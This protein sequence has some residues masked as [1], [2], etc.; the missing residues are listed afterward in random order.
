LEPG[1]TD[2]PARD[3]RFDGPTGI[4][5]D[6][7]GNLYVADSRNNRIRVLSPDGKTST[8]A[9]GDA[10]FQDGDAKQ[11]RFNAPTGVAVAPDGTVYVADTLNHR[12]RAISKGM[13]STVSGGAAG[14]VDGAAANARFNL[15]SGLSI[16]APT[17]GH[18]SPLYVA[19]AGNR[20]I[21]AVDLG[22]S[23]VVRT[24][25]V[26]PGA[27]LSV[28]AITGAGPED[29]VATVPE[30]QTISTN[31]QTLK[32]IPIDAREQAGIVKPGTFELKNPVSLWPS[33]ANNKAWFALDSGHAVV[34]LIR[35]GKAEVI[36]GAAAPKA[37]M[38]GFRDNFGNRASFGLMGGIVGDGKG[39]LYISDTSNNAIRKI[40]LPKDL[41]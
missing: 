30:T 26:V 8:L 33:A 40:T 17:A 16:G 41:Y 18:G 20:S 6:A 37:N 23:P 31:T 11:A 32:A 14:K 13:V 35:N 9:G 4:A 7:S 21:R 19:D 39:H 38:T 29:I 34:F 2:G 1:Q 22:P 12:I 24:V 25:R 28:A 3:S 27:P 5:I 15:P 36:A 10:G